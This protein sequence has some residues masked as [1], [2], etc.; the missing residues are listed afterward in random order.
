MRI[1]RP[2]PAIAVA[3]LLTAGCASV[4]P[5]PLRP[6]PVPY[7]DTLPISE[8]KERAPR[9]V[10]RLLRV[11]VGD[12]AAHPLSPRTLA[13]DRREALNLTRFDDVVGSAWY[14]PRNRLEDPLDPSAVERGPATIDGPSPEGPL[15][16]VAGKSR[17]I[18]PGF[19][20]R[21]ARGDL[22]LF[23]FDPKGY[24]NL[25]S[26]AGV[27]ANRVFHAA[28]YHVPEDY[29]V[30][31]DPA[32]L[33]L[34]SE[35]TLEGEEYEERRMGP[36]DIREILS[37]TDSLPDGRYRALASRFVPGIPK[38]PFHFEGR[39]DDDPNDHYEH[40]HRREL[41]GLYVV[42]SWVNHIDARFANT[43][44]AY[45]APGYLR[46]H[47]IDFA[48]SL[49]SGTIRPHYPREG[50]EYNFDFWPSVARAL[51]LGFYR[52]GWEGMEVEAIHPSIGWMR[53]ESFDPG[54]WRPN[55]P[56]EAWRQMTP[57]DTYW[58]AKLVAAIG[59]EQIRAAVASGRLPAVAADTLAEILIHRRDTTVAHW[60]ARVTPIER[61]AVVGAER[62]P[63]SVP[64]RALA[65]GSGYG[66]IPLGF[67]DLGLALG[68]RS[69][70]ETRY[71]WL[72]EHEALGRWSRGSAPASGRGRQRLT[73][74][75]RDRS[76]V[77]GVSLARE[78]SI[79]TVEVT[80]HRPGSEGRRAVI[81]LRWAGPGLG[82]EVGGIRH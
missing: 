60:F 20:I 44:D 35:A 73:I 37:L 71:R 4:P 64:D 81:Y 72:F 79:A 41:R 66:T 19:T 51:T 9:E 6:E 29:I 13:G 34:E 47:L 24:P 30:V 45:V 40:Q 62:A 50:L 70:E 63:G 18:S 59:D 33:R 52:R 5:V 8:P 27:I 82:Y 78:D 21:D 12:E 56:N 54:A 57:A 14:V 69:P 32:R 31:F 3:C 36:A 46:H 76:D 2:G 65:N 48:A 58:G 23:K 49:G 42:A 28:G 39:R 7:A 61:P 25:G 10:W 38:G 15:A 11:S 53:V 68:L 1:S 17:G 16:V 77:S 74:G 80:A 67:D 43:L 55:W 26:G 75:F 22:Y